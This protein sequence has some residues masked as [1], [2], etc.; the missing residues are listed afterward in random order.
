MD[1]IRCNTLTFSEFDFNFSREVIGTCS[2]LHSF[3]FIFFK[4]GIETPNQ[5]L[6]AFFFYESTT[7][8]TNFRF[9]F[10][11]FYVCM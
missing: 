4:F 8:G 11:C 2:T 10:V 9:M 7:E 5:I 6:F 1:K 3:L